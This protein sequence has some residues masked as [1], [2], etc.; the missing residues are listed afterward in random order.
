MRHSLR[1]SLA[2][3]LSFLVIGV[4]GPGR[5]A[6][7]SADDDKPAGGRE[8]PPRF[9]PLEYLIGSWKGQ[10][11]SRDDPAL[12]FRGWPET[13][14]WAWSFADGKPAGMTLRAEG[15]KLLSTAALT[16]DDDRQI[17]R[18]KAEPTGPKKEPTVYEGTLDESGK[19][20]TLDRVGLDADEPGERLT[21]RPNANS[22]RYTL[23]IERRAP[24]STR[25]SR[26]IEVGLTKEGETFAAGSSATE[27]PKCLIT[28]GAA[29]LT[30]AYKGRTYPICCSG[31][32][33]EFL[34]NPEKYVKKASLRASSSAS[35]DKPAKPT[36][37]RP[38]RS[39]DPFAD[40]VAED[41]MDEPA[42]THDQKPA[43]KDQ[44]DSPPAKD[45]TVDRAASLLRVAQNLEKIGKTAAALENYRE[46]LEDYPDSPSAKTARARVKAL[47]KP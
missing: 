17:F 46:I 27:A 38:R 4:G 35:D 20:L 10:G 29:T 33:D 42:K 37:A 43:P 5:A 14:S 18:L 31:C 6:K 11:V 21:L 30:V 45:S 13:H 28:G 41:K 22:I 15:S 7:L 47:S 36:P 34:E 12:K 39:D 16:F 25:Y 3:V 8:I 2:L 1:P 9:A 19:L 26:S 32:R 40:D 23:A 24:R 44:P